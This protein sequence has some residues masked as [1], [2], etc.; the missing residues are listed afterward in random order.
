M[1]KCYGNIN[2]IHRL[3]NE[4]YQ[5]CEEC[6]K[7]Q[8]DQSL[9]LTSGRLNGEKRKII[10]VRENKNFDVTDRIL[11]IPEWKVTFLLIIS[12]QHLKRIRI[13]GEVHYN[14]R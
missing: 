11:L 2:Y 8:R 12:A 1:I 6:E 5:Q 10:S 7:P 14:F 13:R 9:G 3:L 4:S